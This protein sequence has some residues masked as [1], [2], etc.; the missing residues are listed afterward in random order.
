MRDEDFFYALGYAQADGTLRDSSGSMQLAFLSTERQIIQDL[1]DALSIGGSIWGGRAR[2]DRP[3][4]KPVWGI[5][6][7]DRQLVGRFM[8]VG[9]RK[10]KKYKAE[11]F[12]VPKA[13]RGHFL[14]GY[15]DADG[16][17]SRVNKKYLRMN[18]S[19]GSPKYYDWL[20][21]VL[22]EEGGSFKV[23]PTR[24]Y[25]QIHA[26]GANAKPILDLMYQDHRLCNLRKLE[27]AREFL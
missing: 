27:R 22:K 8:S 24:N 20:Q 9:L 12:D 15:W 11:A 19:S 21:G 10:D 3:T 4:H 25:F 2:E 6:T 23:Y 13:M 5:G 26:A 16:C 1:K 7:T 18:A 14:R 17:I